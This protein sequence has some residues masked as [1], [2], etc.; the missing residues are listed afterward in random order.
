MYKSPDFLYFHVA[1]EEVNFVN[2]ILEGYEYLG[3]MTTIDVGKSIIMLRTTPDTKPL[4]VEILQSL[5]LAVDVLDDFGTE[6][7]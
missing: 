6:K 1:P 5:P 4:A 3:V 7:T 2:R